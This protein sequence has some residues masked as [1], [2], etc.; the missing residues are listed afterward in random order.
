MP[1]QFMDH[2][3]NKKSDITRIY[4]PPDANCLISC[5]DHAQANKDHINVIIASKHPSYQWLTMEQAVEHCKAGV[6]VWKWAS[7]DE[8]KDPDIVIASA[9]DTATIEALACVQ[10]I[11]ELLPDVRVRYVNVVDIMK[12]ETKENYKNGMTDKEFD[13]IFT[14]N[15]PVIFNFHGYKKLIYELIHSRRNR[16][17]I[18]HGYHEE[19]SITTAF[20]MR[21]LNHIDRYNL[22]L[23]VLDKLKLTKTRPDLVK[24][25]NGKLEKHVKYVS[26]YGVDM[27]EIE[28]WKWKF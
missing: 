5:Y 16:N 13:E 11:K 27:P 21:V 18:C 23:S 15:K 8:G 25:M 9:G 10:L 14:T 12:L 3:I 19:G 24:K 22:M 2:I 20:D 17:F 1:I 7:T 28:N 26:E 6:S 4:L